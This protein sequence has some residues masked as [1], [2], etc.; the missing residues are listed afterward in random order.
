M[1]HANPEAVKKLLR[2]AI[3]V[4]G[5]LLVLT[6]LTVY[7]STIDLGHTGNI[8]VA[9]LIA[10]VKA[11]LVGA[12]FMHLISEKTLIY[13]VLILGA[14]FFIVMMGLPLFQNYD[15]ISR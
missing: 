6:V 1:D 7:A 9:L 12:Y 11:S 5:V 10:T 3:I 13:S 4:F 15:P 2:Q 8:I 14:V